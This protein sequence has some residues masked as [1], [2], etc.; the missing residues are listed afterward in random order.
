MF[1]KEGTVHI[2]LAN[3]ID[4][5]ALVDFNQA[6]AVETE[7]KYLDPGVLRAG[8]AAVFQDEKKGFYVVVEDAGNIVGGLLIT[9]EWSD[10]RSKWFWWIQSVYIVPAARGQNIY[11]RLY[12]FV[13]TKAEENGDVCGFR[14]YV[15][16]ENLVAQKV[17]ER[18]GMESSYYLMYE[19]KV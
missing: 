2:R 17:Y 1:V 12:E 10:W 18:V 8:V 5:D 11:R 6:M 15:E 19:E 4:E 3:K 7:G 9:F 14:L 13:K 16:K